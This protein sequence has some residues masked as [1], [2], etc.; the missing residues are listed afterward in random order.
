MGMAANSRWAHRIATEYIKESNSIQKT[1][2]GAQ[3][4]PR[5][6]C[7]QK[8]QTSTW[9][10]RLPRPCRLINIRLESRLRTKA[11][12]PLPALSTAHRRSA[13]PSKLMIN[14]LCS[15]SCS[16]PHRSSS[17]R[18]AKIARANNRRT[19]GKVAAKIWKLSAMT[20]QVPHFLKTPCQAKL[21]K[22][23]SSFLM[24]SIAI[25]KQI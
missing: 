9:S 12:L 15:R 21:S 4:K 10:R 14:L 23:F 17:P 2:R 25:T 24:N 11:K 6:K 16:Q 8:I 1:L 22:C 20:R 7:G 18:R 5:G 19:L 3:L 13:Q